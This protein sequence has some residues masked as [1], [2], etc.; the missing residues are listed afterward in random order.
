MEAAHLAGCRDVSDWTSAEVDQPFD[1]VV[2]NGG[3]YPLDETFYQTVKG[4]VTA[5]PALHERSTL[6]M[7]SGCG[8]VGSP[9]Y[10]DLMLR[11]AND[12]PRF[13]ED[14]AALPRTSKDQ[15]QYQMQTRVLERIGVERLRLVNDGLEPDTQQ[16]LSVNPVLGRGSANERAQRF[17]DD[18][19]AA[20]PG[21]RVAVIPEGPYTMLTR[22]VLSEAGTGG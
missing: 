20:H 2:T 11:Y 21:A 6:L 9:E 22:P 1:L 17:I 15:W 4:M 13:L 3:G 16:R 18:Y 5:L 10:T 7:V 8:E 19:V 12:W 14:I